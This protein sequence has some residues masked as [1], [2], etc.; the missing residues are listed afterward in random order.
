MPSP[1]MNKVAGKSSWARFEESPATRLT[2]PKH[3]VKTR[4]MSRTTKVA[5]LVSILAVAARLIWIDQP[6]VD[7]WS[8]RQSDVA[9]IARN[10]YRG[11]F[12]FAHPQIDWAGN[13]P[14]YVG[15]EFPILPFVAAVCY[16]VLGVHE[17]VGR[18]QAVIL[19]A[20]SLPFFFL[21]VRD[22]WHAL[23]A[24]ESCQ[25][26]AGCRCHVAA[27]WALFFYE[28]A[29]LS[30]FTSRD[31]M[32]DIPSLSLAII[33][34][35][36]FFRWINTERWTFLS[37]GAVATSLALLI[38]LPSAVIAAPLG[39]LA[40]QKWRWNLLRQ[41][42]LWLFAAATLLPSA[43]WYW[44]AYEIAARFYPH[45]FFGAGGVRIMDAHWYWKIAK[46]IAISSLTPVLLGLA[47]LG[48][49]LARSTRRAQL[50]YWWLGA[51]IVFIVAVGYG[52]RHQWYQ[53]SLV[54]IAAVFA[55]VAC[56][57]VGSKISARSV[58]VASS[59]VLAGVFGGLAF[60]SVVPLYRSHSAVALRGLGLE[61]NRVAPRSALIVAADNG[62]PTVF[63]Y[64]QRKGWHLLEKGGIY[65]GEPMDATE[66][67]VDLNKLR[68]RGATHLVFTFN[69]S[70]WLDYYPALAQDVEATATLLE[71]TPEFKIYRLNP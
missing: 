8:W 51:I 68:D 19:F 1:D 5:I 6:F 59:I 66:A 11:G 45:H 10:F 60:T 7:N 41:P 12:H 61:L 13:E 65:Q 4:S 56:A 58:K 16:K 21:L 33:G 18:V 55:A 42:A 32:P 27:V 43:I 31:F 57:F 36:F 28:F 30:I 62:D 25:S 29:P 39:C 2:L 50:F 52:S 63:Y 37:A 26:S 22:T 53:L 9:A 23:P 20:G 3:F 70:W 46:Q 48:A 14:G 69:T 64:A 49:F 38:K 17:W 35:Y 54:P 67:I 24:H 34:L 40:W 44:H 71:A 47:A 15:T